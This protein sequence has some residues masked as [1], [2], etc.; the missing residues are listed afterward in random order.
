MSS[1]EIVTDYLSLNTTS[2]ELGVTRLLVGP[3]LLRMKT[4]NYVMN[5][6]GDLSVHQ[7]GAHHTIVTA[8]RIIQDKLREAFTR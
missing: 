5:A 1:P 2:Q 6:T 4:G 8:H 7:L 3:P